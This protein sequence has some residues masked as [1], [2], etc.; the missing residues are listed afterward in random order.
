MNKN[1]IGNILL[2]LSSIFFGWHSLLYFEKEISV[3]TAG[4]FPLAIS[5]I[6]GSL[7]LFSIIKEINGIF[8]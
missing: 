4:F 6:L 8:K 2:F 1:I 7:S 5:I 3:L